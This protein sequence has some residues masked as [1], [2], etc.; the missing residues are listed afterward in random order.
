MLRQAEEEDTLSN[1]QLTQKKFFLRKTKNNLEEYKN[2]A[3]PNGTPRHSK[4]SDALIEMMCTKVKNNG[5]ENFHW[6]CVL[7]KCNNCPGLTTNKFECSK[8]N[9]SPNDA[10]NFEHYF[11]YSRCPKLGLLGKGSIKECSQC[12]IENNLPKISTKRE[13]TKEKMTIYSFMTNYYF[14]YLDKYKF[15]YPHMKILSAQQCVSQQKIAFRNDNNSLFTSRDYAEAFNVIL[16]G[17]IQNDHF[18][19]VPKIYLESSTAKFHNKESDATEQNYLA[20]FSDDTKQHASTSRQNMK[21]EFLTM[22]DNNLLQPGAIIYD[23]S[24]GC[25]S[26]YRSATAIEFMTILCCLF[27]VT[28]D[29][30]IH[31]PSHGKGTVDRSAAV[32]KRFLLMC[33]RNADKCLS[34]K[35][36]M[37]YRFY[38]WMHSDGEENS[39]AEQ[40]VML[41]SSKFSKEEIND[42]DKISDSGNKRRKTDDSAV[43]DIKVD[44]T[45]IGY[46]NKRKKRDLNKSITKYHFRKTSRCHVEYQNIKMNTIKLPTS[47]Q[48]HG[49]SSAMYNIRTDPQLGYGKAALRRIPCACPSCINQLSLPWDA[50]K[51]YTDQPRYAQNMN[52]V[53]WSIFEGEND[54]QIVTI[55]FTNSMNDDDYEHFAETVFE[56]YSQVVRET[57]T[58]G[59]FGAV[60]VTSDH[61]FEIIHFTN[62]PYVFNWS[63]FKGDK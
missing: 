12:L 40:A 46:G 30:M 31:A 1:V 29:R 8:Y 17:E 2:F 58:P 44:I 9:S 16:N 10:I 55:N 62:K 3:F 7:G 25:C 18:G 43:R 27:G 39:F 5:F 52:C 21:E 24:D 19:W 50:L 45:P 20:H 63:T 59:S 4:P 32:I 28:I 42:D 22:K 51:Q 49:G 47:N 34:E 38:P 26:Q 57:I 33:M 61:E 53:H 23:H 15:H 41:C 48:Q 14:K 56:E 54:W 6:K 36:E 35:K 37:S 60:A 11:Q 13:R